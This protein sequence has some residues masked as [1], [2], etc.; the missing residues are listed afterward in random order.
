[1]IAFCDTYGLANLVKAP[2]CYKNPQNPS[3]I[4]LILTNK[5]KSYFNTLVLETGLSDFH[6][7]TVTVMRANLSKMKP[8]SVIYR[9]YKHYINENF[10]DDL[11]KNL[12]SADAN[13]TYEKFEKNYLKVLEGHAP[14]KIKMIRANEAP[15][16]NKE[17][18]KSIMK[19]SRLRNRYLRFP[20]NENNVAYK[21]QRNICTNMLRKYKRDYYNNLNTN[22][23]ADD[24]MF[25]KTVKPLFSDKINSS[26]KIT[27]IN[28]NKITSENSDI[29]QIFNDFFSTAASKLNI[30]IVLIT[31]W[32]HNIQ[33]TPFLKLLRNRKNNLVSS[34]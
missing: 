13:L 18:K 21:I 5:P 10:R 22:P 1:M 24:E 26:H 12:N 9:C 32:M 27:L 17:M 34:R 16:V 25:W 30:E 8:I 33:R 19:R 20:S 11:A 2:T 15:F 14:C 31:L 23:I 6:K 3:C 4:D 28:E 29:A 7:M